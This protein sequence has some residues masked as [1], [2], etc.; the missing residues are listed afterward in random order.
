[1]NVSTVDVSPFA[2]GCE[3]LQAAKA[4]SGQ[5]DDVDGD[6]DGNAAS[7]SGS[8]TMTKSPWWCASELCDPHG[9]V[10]V[11]ARSWL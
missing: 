5:V 10:W 7:G 1:M 4:V 8:I 2:S 3:L 11:E 9:D 6:T